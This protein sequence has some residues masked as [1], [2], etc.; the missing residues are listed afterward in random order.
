MPNPGFCVV[1]RGGRTRFQEPTPL[2]RTN[3]G[4]G[5]GQKRLKTP[6]Q[7]IDPK[8]KFAVKSQIQQILQGKTIQVSN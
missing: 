3:S 5:S 7:A 4:R 8:L 2:K 6:I 1:V